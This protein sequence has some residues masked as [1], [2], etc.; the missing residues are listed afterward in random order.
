M[1][2]TLSSMPQEIEVILQ[3]V[4]LELA[5]HLQASHLAVQIGNNQEEGGR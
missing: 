4:A 2:I 5:R 1:N 3:T